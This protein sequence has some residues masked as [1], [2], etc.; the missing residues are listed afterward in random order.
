MEYLNFDQLASRLEPILATILK[1][2]GTFAGLLGDELSKKASGGIVSATVNVVQSLGKSAWKTGGS[3][4]AR[5]RLEKRWGAS[6][7]SDER[8]QVLRQFF[9]EDPARAQS[10]RATLL[11]LD[12][13][14]AVAQHA[15][16]L[17]NVSLL[18]VTK[19]LS[20]VYVPLRIE[21]ADEREH[22]K[23][24]SI[25]SGA[26]K[27]SDT[28]SASNISAVELL[29]SGNHLIEG[30]PGSGK[31]TLARRFVVSEARKI[32]GNKDNLYFEKVRLPVLVAARSFENAQSDF[33]SA[34]Q[35]AASSEMSLASL[36]AFPK[37]FFVPYS[38]GGHKLWL[39]VVDG[40]DE[41]EDGRERQRL[42]D[43]LI[44][45]HS[46]AGDAFRF[47][48]FSRPDAIRI[49][50]EEDLNFR[51]W[52]VCALSQS[53]SSLIAHRYIDQSRKAEEFL[54]LIRTDAL[55]DTYRT[56]LFQSIAASVFNRTGGMPDT[57]LELCEAFITALIEK[58]GVSDLDR[59]SLLNLLG[60]V[61]DCNKIDASFVERANVVGL[62]SK[63]LPRVQVRGALEN[64]VKM[65][66][67]A[68]VSGESVT[69]L[70]DVFRSYFLIGS[71]SKQH[72][73]TESIWK[74]L[75]PFRLGWTTVQFLCESWLWLA[76]TFQ[77]RWMVC[78]LLVKM[79]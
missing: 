73:P 41:I 7:T 46:R 59:P 63:Q 54:G 49:R 28:A 61:A 76:R 35:T 69:F 60:L 71:L 40:L 8:Q 74:T 9:S 68:R 57:R 78:S 77:A 47:V 43:I 17:P 75:D 79:V 26:A 15:E 51:R 27:L 48:V 66:G 56:P 31:S 18:D 62:F 55:A 53:D 37:D 1:E 70:H 36:A 3:I 6:T 5:R 33:S 52:K 19:R 38:E 50:A 30:G 13:L 23:N 42:W 20:D 10:L 25:L 67:L 22:S 58:S 11:R 45:L 29:S 4:R 72:E 44:K 24:P 16:Q 64:V 12:F 32:L 34:L 39:V 65:T 21:R 14:R 2:G